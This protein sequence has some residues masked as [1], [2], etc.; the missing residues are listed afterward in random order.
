MSRKQWSTEKR[1]RKRELLKSASNRR[2]NNPEQSVE[3][4]DEENEEKDDQN[5][6]RLLEEALDLQDED[7]LQEVILSNSN[8][9]KLDFGEVIEEENEDEEKNNI[10]MFAQN[11][12]LNRNTKGVHGSPAQRAK[13]L[14]KITAVISEGIGGNVPG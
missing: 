6:D 9:Q 10:K 7:D 2:F 4:D 11:E 1:R 3:S 12:D 14:A 5:L 8:Y 13:K